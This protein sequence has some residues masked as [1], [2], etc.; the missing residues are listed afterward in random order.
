MIL[1]FVRGTAWTSTLIAWQEKA[2]LPFTPSHVE[3]LTSDG[4]SYIGAHIDGGVAVRP[5]GYDKGQVACL[6]HGYDKTAFPGGLCDLHLKLD[7]TPAQDKDFYSYMNAGIGEPYDWLSIIG[8]VVP[9]HFHLRNHVI[10]SAKI[11]L[12]LRA[13]EWFPFRLSA[14]AHLIDPRDLLLMLS[15]HMQI[16]GV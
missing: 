7:A 15:T 13:A 16:P 12:A 2:A 11:S 6:P 9:E 1:R 10:C 3:A 14:A 8:F 4:K 5:I